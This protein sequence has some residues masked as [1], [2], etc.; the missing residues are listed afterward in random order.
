M[1]FIRRK[2]RNSVLQQQGQSVTANSSCGVQWL[3]LKQ[4]LFF[5]YLLLG[6]TFLS[7]FYDFLWLL[8]LPA[9]HKDL[10]CPKIPQYTEAPH[11]VPVDLFP[12]NTWQVLA[13]FL[14]LGLCFY[15]FYLHSDNV[16]WNS[17]ASVLCGL[18]WIFSWERNK[19]NN[20]SGI[21]LY[22]AGW[23]IFKLWIISTVLHWNYLFCHDLILPLA[24]SI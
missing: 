24:L 10:N 23:E 16:N 6:T 14:Y 1:L 17:S 11:L 8:G 21:S 12:T 13:A 9:A 22:Q 15:I 7:E 19:L 20:S 3:P 4:I 18:F 2:W 5:Y